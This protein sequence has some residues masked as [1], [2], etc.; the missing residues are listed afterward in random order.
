MVIN[1]DLMVCLCILLI[2]LWC[3]HVIEIP[4]DNNITVF[5]RGISMGLN[6]L[7]PFGG[8]VIPISIVGDNLLW[9]NAQKKEIKKNTSDTMKRIIPIFNP[10]T[11]LI[12]CFPWKVPSRTMSR[13][14]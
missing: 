3:D 12:V 10:F 9:K 4:D 11:T 2:I 14:H 1:R 5:N 7:M 6:V 8:H 13:H